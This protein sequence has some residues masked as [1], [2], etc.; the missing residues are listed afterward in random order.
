M[1]EL[2]RKLIHLGGLLVP[3]LYL[4]FERN[5]ALFICGLMFIVALVGEVLRAFIPSFNAFFLSV[6]NG[7][8]REHEKEKLLGATYLTASSFLSL[9]LFPLNVAVSC[10]L[11]LVLGDTFAALVGRKFGRHRF[12][13]KSWEG[14]STF[15]I[16]S[17]LSSLYFIGLPLSFLGALT[18]TITEAYSDKDN[19]TVPL[20][21]GAV[22]SVFSLLLSYP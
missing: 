18:A 1:D 9:L 2:L 5:T 8:T 15:F 20:I 22:L 4:A 6:F 17:F 3:F 12:S 7:V 19:L 10:M 11:Y 14:S 16:V 21:S 13:E